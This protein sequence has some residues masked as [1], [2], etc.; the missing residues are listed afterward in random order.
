[1]SIWIRTAGMVGLAALLI[2]GITPPVAA[3]FPIGGFPTIEGDEEGGGAPIF[4]TWSTSYMDVNGDGDIADF[5]V[6]VGNQD[7]LVEE[8]VEITLESGEFGFTPEEMVTIVESFNVWENEPEAFV[9]FRYTEPVPDPLPVGPQ[10]GDNILT[11]INDVD[12]LN[13]MSITTPEEGDLGGGILGVT[14]LAVAIEDGEIVLPDETVLIVNGGQIIDSD[15]AYSGASHRPAAPG[16]QPA[17]ELLATA[18]HENGH[19]IGIDHNPMNNIFEFLLD[20]EDQIVG[21]IEQ[22]PF[23]RRVNGV[24][25]RVGVTPTMFNFVFLVEDEGGVLSD[26]GSDLAPDD[27]A[28]LAFLYPRRSNSNYFTI[29]AEARTQNREGFPSLPNPG[30]FITAWID[31]DGLPETN[32][33]PFV[34][35]MVGLYEDTEETGGQFELLGLQKQVETVTAELI[36]ANY[37][38]TIEPLNGTDLVGSG[39]EETNSMRRLQGTAAPFGYNTLFPSEVFRE[40]GNLFDAGNVE[41]GTALQ[42]DDGGLRGRVI[43]ADS[44]RPLNRILA[45]GAPMFGDANP[46]PIQTLFSVGSLSASGTPNALRGFRDDVLLQTALG[47]AVVDAYYAAAPAMSAFLLRHATL[48]EAGRLVARA[49]DAAVHHRILIGVAFL[50]LIAARLMRRRRVRQAIA[51]MLIAL[52]GLSLLASPAQAQIIP[53][54]VEKIVEL[55]DAVVTGEVVSVESRWTDGP[56]MA[57]VT[58]ITIQVSDSVKGRVNKGSQVHITLPGGRIGILATLVSHMPTFKE[59]EEVLVFLQ[60]PT[61]DAGGPN[62]VVGGSQG[63]LVIKTDASTGEKIVSAPNFDA[64]YVLSDAAKKIQA[65]KAKSQA[66]GDPP[67]AAVNLDDFKSYLRDVVSAQKSR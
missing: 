43:S 21:T 54:S 41:L 45:F 44:G 31:H 15:I 42:W 18:V 11:S 35:T 56:R 20:D 25:Q 63:K 49:V 3:F 6:Q 64:S 53:L 13:Y 30:G 34:S 19:F 61:K 52:L 1:V 65:K 46:C 51:P 2:I 57:I 5:I 23:T 60:A 7:V 14:F 62:M 38:I 9:A 37:A 66:Q 39:P 67:T 27:V 16:E 22:A 33:L 29:Q 10:G 40:G 28:A 4:I 32:R 12:F 50:A 58:D 8:G 36:Q 48:L 55:S 17:F 47:A 24:L 26:G 59:K